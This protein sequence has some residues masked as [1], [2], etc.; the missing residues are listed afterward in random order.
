MP[1]QM[2]NCPNKKCGTLNIIGGLDNCPVCGAE[3]EDVAAEASASAGAVA[4][5]A[6]T[7]ASGGPPTEESAPPPSPQS[8][9]KKSGG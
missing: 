9:R 5:E 7:G 8:G 4:G 6:S 1:P 3:N 2:W